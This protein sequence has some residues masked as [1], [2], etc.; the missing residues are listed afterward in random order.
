MQSPNVGL[1]LLGHLLTSNSRKR[2]VKQ[3]PESRSGGGGR[4]VNKV[5]VEMVM[6]VSG[7][8]VE[9]D[10]LEQFTETY[11]HTQAGQ[12]VAPRSYQRRV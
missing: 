11:N 12:S 1:L 8:S 4:G 10:L 9:A 2:S 7:T 3:E 5:T 6:I